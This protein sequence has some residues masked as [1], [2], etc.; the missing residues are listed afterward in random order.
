LI[1]VAT[2]GIVGQAAGSLR[3][4]TATTQMGAAAP[5]VV[6]RPPAGWAPLRVA[7]LWEYRELLYFLTKRELQIRYKQ[8]VFGVSWALLQPLVL[9]FIF[10]VFFGLLANVPS[11][12]LPYPVFAL[13]GLVPWL[14]VSQTVA[15]SAMSLVSDANLLSKVYFP[16]LVIPLA[17]TL[18]L[19][20]DLVI[21]L[22]VLL[23]FA[24]AYGE[25]PD[26]DA[27]LL[28]AFLLLALLTGCGVGILLAA[29]NVQYRDVGVA[30][31]L[32]IQA[33]L[34]ATPVIYPG[35]L[36][37]GAWA[38]VYAVNP[39]VT[40][41]DGVRWTLLGTEPPNAAGVAISVTVALCVGAAALGYF[42]RTE[43]FFAD[44]V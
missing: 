35:S 38:Y 36:V 37:T 5:T 3:L 11:E 44:V 12:G 42:R 13:A 18:A 22:G 40:V 25:T 23:I 28:P 2:A 24:L 34:F 16:R 43:L 4:V 39:M 31:P 14:F 9:T 10:A 30:V 20:V 1:A 8:S 27:L 15:Q 7:D 21:A 19:L 32:L 26:L 41:V 29:V 6:I 17:K 33:W